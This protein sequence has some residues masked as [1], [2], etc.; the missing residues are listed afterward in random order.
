M[1][2]TPPESKPDD[3]RETVE[4][5][6]A[7]VRFR[8]LGVI[9]LSLFV[10]FFITG[11]SC[12]FAGPSTPD[13][14]FAM[15]GGVLLVHL[16]VAAYSLVI[17][18]FTLISAAVISLICLTPSLFFAGI[19]IKDE[20]DSRNYVAPEEIRDEL[21]DVDAPCSTSLSSDKKTLEFQ[22]SNGVIMKLVLIP[23]G[24]FMM[25]SPETETGRD[26]DEG[27]QREVTIS[28]PF[29][30]G[31]Y[32]VT[33]AQ[34]R[35]V[36]GTLPWKGK[37]RDTKSADNNAADFITWNRA[38]EFCRLLSKKTGRKAVLPTEA[39]WEYACRAG[40]KTAY[41]FGDDVS[42]LGDYAWYESNAYVN[43][44]DG[45]SVHVVGQKKPNAF[46]LYDMHGNAWECCQD[47]YEEKFYEGKNSVDPKNTTETRKRVTRG[48]GAGFSP[49]W[50]R[51]ANR[52]PDDPDSNTYG[53]GNG[54]RVLV[55]WDESS[56]AD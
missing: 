22:F 39:Q 14:L 10:S 54:F 53:S 42:K 37:Y 12:P 27:P 9:A 11:A 25:G 6:A 50:C 41:N 49:S 56:A 8:H 5:S 38:S 2:I 55:V 47:W 1:T 24:K 33:Q 21:A 40:S 7:G 51:S 23:A 52:E 45:T 35:A 4:V 28:R 48:G 43:D 16:I 3:V 17:P 34:W 20:I 26:D 19:A 32:E 18:K 46:G 36:M 13:V 30:L 29:Y 44:V 15:L 31:V